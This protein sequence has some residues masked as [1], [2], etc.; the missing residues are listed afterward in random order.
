[1][2]DSITY[3]NWTPIFEW[4]TYGEVWLQGRAPKGHM[5]KRGWATRSNYNN[6]SRLSSQLAWGH[7]YDH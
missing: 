2:P 1:M 6:R 5:S 4:Y 7:V 3:L